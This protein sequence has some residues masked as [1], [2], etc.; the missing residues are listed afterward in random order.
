MGE[1]AVECGAVEIDRGKSA[2]EAEELVGNGPISC[3]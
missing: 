1:V 3:C 2:I